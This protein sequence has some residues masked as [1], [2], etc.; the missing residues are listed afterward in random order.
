MAAFEIAEWPIIANLSQTI[1]RTRFDILGHSATSKS[2]TSAPKCRICRLDAPFDAPKS[3]LSSALRISAVRHTYDRI[4][5]VL[6][7]LDKNGHFINVYFFSSKLC[8]M[9]VVLG[10]ARTRGSSFPKFT[11]TAL[12]D[13]VDNFYKPQVCPY[14]TSLLRW[15]V[16]RKRGKA[17]NDFKSYG[18][19]AGAPSPLFSSFQ[20]INPTFFHTSSK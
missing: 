19:L 20:Y 4:T 13:N 3:E 14:K 7:N 5:T 17:V 10:R 15:R 6:W 18:K 2:A 8:K 11:P 12:I 9:P 16:W 1:W